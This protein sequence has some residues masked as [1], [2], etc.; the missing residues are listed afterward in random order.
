[1]YY[2]IK[3]AFL[4]PQEGGML[5]GIGFIKIRFLY[6]GSIVNKSMISS[7]LMLVMLDSL[8][9]MKVSLRICFRSCSFMIFSSMVSS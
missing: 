9:L 1:M 5:I 4:N 8:L 3:E 2:C 7:L 6:K